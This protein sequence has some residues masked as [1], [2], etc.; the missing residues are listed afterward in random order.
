[1]KNMKSRRSETVWFLPGSMKQD[2]RQEYTIWSPGKATQRKKTPGNL[3]LQSRISESG[4]AP[5]TK[6]TQTRRQR[7]FRPST[8]PRQGQVRQSSQASLPRSESVAA[9]AKTLVSQERA[10]LEVFIS[11]FN[12]FWHADNLSVAQ[13]FDDPP[14]EFFTQLSY[15]LYPL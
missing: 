15:C 3:H 13:F 14:T 11:F 12:G 7:L 4:S 1:M 8:S 2:G 5:F 6:T 10:E 9:P